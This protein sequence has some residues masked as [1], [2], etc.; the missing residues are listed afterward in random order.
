MASNPM[1][2]KSRNSFLLGIIVTLL[3]TGVVIAVLLLMLKQ[4]NDELQAE[5]NSKVRVY[6]LTQDVR[7]G[8]IL[9]EEMF[10]LKTI[11]KDSIPS[12]ATATPQ[13][14]E[15]WFLQTKAG[16]A[17]HTDKYGLYLDRTFTDSAADTII[18]V[19]K[20]TLDNR[21][22]SNYKNL[23]P[24]NVKFMDQQD[25]EL[26]NFYLQIKSIYL[27]RIKRFEDMKNGK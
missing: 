12:N 7:A 6:T 5:L 25:E 20:N 22:N 8:Q 18:E 21:D 26:L 3:I 23:D 19:L 24:D 13:V 2:R 4:K 1:Q 27:N 11:H 10:A 16:E 14:I 15:T 17:V 9:T